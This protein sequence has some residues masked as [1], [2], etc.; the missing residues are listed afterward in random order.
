MH[1]E[2]SVTA[3][4]FDT[5][6]PPVPAYHS[7]A[8]AQDMHAGCCWPHLLMHARVMPACAVHDSPLA[9]VSKGIDIQLPICHHIHVFPPLVGHAQSQHWHGL[10]FHYQHPHVKAPILWAR[11]NAMSQT[12][13]ICTPP[14]STTH[15]LSRIFT[16]SQ[17]CHL[18]PT[19]SA[20][21]Y[22]P[23]RTVSLR[24]LNSPT[25]ATQGGLP[26]VRQVVH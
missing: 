2:R 14:G 26:S 19:N 12:P 6:M 17:R 20:S 1:S 18:N 3:S 24:Y 4:L 13:A 16:S 8:S 10:H 7:D 22:L 15:Q 5:T 9:G 25:S 21:S 23:G 11:R